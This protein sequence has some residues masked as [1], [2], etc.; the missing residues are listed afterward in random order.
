MSL[1]GNLTCAGSTS[2]TTFG[3]TGGFTYY[4]D[5]G[6]IGSSRVLT[7]FSAGI[8]YIN[9]SVTGSGSTRGLTVRSNL[10]KTLPL[11]ITTSDTPSPFDSQKTRRMLLYAL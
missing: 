6:L 1:S 2:S 9:M 10:L 4:Y 5:N 7:D 3:G 11:E 8:D